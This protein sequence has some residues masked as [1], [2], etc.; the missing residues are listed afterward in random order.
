M[1]GPKPWFLS[2]SPASSLEQLDTMHNMDHSRAALAGRGG[3]TTQN[4]LTYKARAQQELASG[5]TARG[6]SGPCPG[7]CPVT[8]SLPDGA[9]R[10]NLV[11]WARPWDQ[12]HS[13]S[14]MWPFLP[15]RVQTLL[16]LQPQ[17][18]VP[19]PPPPA[20]QG[21]LRGRV[22]AARTDLGPWG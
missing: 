2:G 14:G 1:R 3:G 9:G 10:G 13:S 6:Q 5:Q 11:P 7:P 16:H 19:P 17:G 21:L 12:R 4:P 15:F 8:V 18:G 20:H 22:G